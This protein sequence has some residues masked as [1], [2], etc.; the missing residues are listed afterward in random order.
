MVAAGCLNFSSTAHAQLASLVCSSSSGDTT[1]GSGALSTDCSGSNSS[2]VTRAGAVYDATQSG[3]TLPGAAGNFQAPPGAALSNPVYFAAPG[4]YDHDGW[5]DFVA[6]SDADQIYVLRNQTITCGLLGCSGTTLTPPTAQTIPAA[7]W[8]ALSFVRAAAFRSP[9]SSLK[10]GVG[11]NY[12]MT[13]M[14]SGD[15]DGDGWTD[16]V[17]ISMDTRGPGFSL[18]SN[19]VVWPTAARLFM[20]TKNCH[21][22]TFQPCGI[23]RLCTGQPANGAC[24]GSGVAGSGTG[25]A[26]TNLSC[27]TTGTCPYYMPSF[28]TYDVRTGLPVAAAGTYN[29]STPDTAA[30]GD[31]G[32]VGHPVQNMVALDW[33]GDGDLDI[34]Y[35]HSD[36]ACVGSLCS[37]PGKQFYS[38]IDVWKNDCAQSAQWTASTKSCAGHIPIFTHSTA[39]AC[40]GTACANADTLIPSTAHN[41]SVLAPNADLGFDVASKG[42]PGFA[43]VDLDKDGD[44]DLVVGAPGCCAGTANAANRLRVFRGTSGSPYIHTLDTA[45]PISLSTTSGSHPGF[46]G[47]LTGIFVYDFSGDGYPDIITGSDGFAYGSTN[48]GR[49]RYWKNTGNATSPF[50]S[51]WPACSSN[52]LTCAGC[53]STCNPD[54]TAKLSENC[55][56][57][58]CADNLAASP[59]QFPDFDMG[60]MLDYDHDPSHTKDI[61]YTNG[62]T[63]NQ[64][65]IF[66]NRASPSTY[67][68]CGTAA[69][70]T[71]PVPAGELIVSGACVKPTATVPLGTSVTYALS[72]D[73]GASWTSACVQTATGVFLPALV[74]GQCCVAFPTVTN[75]AV[76]WQATMDSN[77][78]DGI[79]VC[80]LSG[81]AVPT[82]TSVAANYTY[83][84]AAQHF[85]AGVTVSDGV[86]YVGSFVEPGDRGHLFAIDSA[87]S[88][89]YWDFAKV[90]DGTDPLHVQGPRHIFTADGVVNGSSLINFDASVAASVLGAPDAATAGAVASWVLGARFGVTLTPSRLGAV[91]SSTPAILAPPFRPNYYTYASA[92]DRGLIDAFAATNATRTPLVLFGAMD[93][94]VHA[95]YS[96]TKSMT[97]SRNGTEAWAY[98]PPLVAGSMFSDFSLTTTNGSLTIASFPDGSPALLDYKKASGQMATAAIIASGTGGSSVT[99]LDVTNTVTSTSVVGPTPM[100]SATPGGALAG[101]AMAKPAAGRAKIGGVDKFVVVAGTG[102]WSSA[103]LLK[104]KTVQGYD[105]ETGTVLWK[106][107]TVCPVTSDITAFETDDAGEPG[108]PTLDGYLDRAVFADACGY[109]YKVNPA[110]DLA[111]GYMSNAGYGTIAVGTSNGATRYALFY[112]ASTPN[113]IGSQRPISG[114]IGARTDSTTNMVLFFGTGG[115]ATYDITKP[116]EFYAVYANTGAVRSKLA[117]ACASLRCEKF[118]GGVV[119]TP[120][121][122]IVERTT[123][124]LIGGLTCDFGTTHVQELG[125]DAGSGTGF[126]SVFDISSI[127]GAPLASVAGPLYGDAGALYFATVSGSVS[128]IGDARDATAGSAPANNGGMASTGGAGTAPSTAAPFTLLGWRA[129]L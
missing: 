8:S 69:S 43:Y 111:G 73:G 97:D 91:V 46:E 96:L 116:N 32:P 81:T 9:P 99:A 92:A 79:G 126:T 17:A 39:G 65:Y 118:Y 50:G 120:D 14:V 41:A 61:V 102:Q 54:A 42:A 125:I 45:N 68:P 34:L 87:L 55:G 70:G 28:A 57:P 86:A 71:L 22:A 44:L 80:S 95:V 89:T 1:Y 35:G 88:N 122:V 56:S 64:F 83:T 6:A 40:T 19:I 67:A 123:D 38:G 107:E 124:P 53:S 76:Q 7:T 115:L 72:N 37:T 108:A 66:P 10:N 117:G 109:V 4:D 114:T 103:D 110:Q 119:V 48:G 104:G 20:N 82:I 84:P 59:P 62:N 58:F 128:R 24:S 49:T 15:F 98:V 75:R 100:W 51:N 12:L 29:A 36:G 94:M 23:G 16:F 26:E 106:F 31:F 60:L 63:S 90:L 25:W 77:L 101:K 18:P 78:A 13:P 113:A 47:A 93:G 30:A 27:T 52:P 21:D 33:D 85:R 129:V 5:D 105:L 112:T 11:Q 121:D 127:G 3:L 74:G 2:C